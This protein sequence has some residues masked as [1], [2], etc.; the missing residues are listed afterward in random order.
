LHFLNAGSDRLPYVSRLL[1][2]TGTR[3]FCSGVVNLVVCGCKTNNKPHK[4]AQPTCYKL[5]DC[6]RAVIVQ[7]G[8]VA[9]TA[10]GGMFAG[11]VGASIGGFMGGHVGNF[12]AGRHAAPH[13]SR[14]TSWLAERMR[15]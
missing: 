10:I 15:R 3:A 12:L 4:R 5:S 11:P 7:F 2:R 9:G 13:I 14:G 8:Q 6:R 1:S